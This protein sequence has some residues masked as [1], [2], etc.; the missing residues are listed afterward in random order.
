M[1][2]R[3][4]KKIPAG[5]DRSATI[6]TS[7]PSYLSRVASSAV[8]PTKKGDIRLKHNFWEMLGQTLVEGAQEGRLD[9]ERFKNFQADIDL[10]IADKWTVN[11]GYNQD[12]GGIRQALKGT[13]SRKF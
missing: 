11:L 7:S 8:T 1:A 4:N 10:E 3:I 2:E 9:P 13:I 6:G 5:A 12:W